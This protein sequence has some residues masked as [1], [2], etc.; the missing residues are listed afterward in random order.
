MRIS[1]GLAKGIALRVTKSNKLRP[2]GDANRERL[3]SSLNEFV[4]EKSVL[5]LFAGT[6]SYGLEALSRGAS[7]AVF[8]EADRRIFNDL[9]LNFANTC[10]SAKLPP[11][12]GQLENRNVSEFLKHCNLSFNLVFMDPPYAEISKLVPVT[13]ELLR[14]RKLLRK[15]CLLVHESPPEAQKDFPGWTLTRTVGKEKKGSPSF[16]IYKSSEGTTGQ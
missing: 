2:A 3:F 4:R 13:L 16:R 15:D 5:D 1:G 8:V 9:K 11:S 14:T 10:R 6:G 12:V 7:G